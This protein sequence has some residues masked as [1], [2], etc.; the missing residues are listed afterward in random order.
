METLEKRLVTA[1]ATEPV[2]SVEAKLHCRVDH[3]AEDALITALITAARTHVENETGQALITQ[4]WEVVLDGWPQVLRLPH[5]PVSAVTSVTYRDEAGVT[6][7]LA[8]TAYTVRT[9]LTPV[10]V[11]FDQDALPAAT[12]ADVG[13]IAVRYTAGYGAAASVPKP[14]FQAM[15]LLIGHWYQNREAVTAQSAGPLAMAVDALLEPY[16]LHWFGPWVV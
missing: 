16:R 11:V 6:A 5:A 7:T 14:I 13:P 8:A 15:L 9:G 3:S 12:L 4:T 2:S 1:P 10:Q